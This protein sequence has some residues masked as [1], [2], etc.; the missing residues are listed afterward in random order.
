M[1]TI[2]IHAYIA[3]SGYTSRRKA[4][5]LVKAKKVFVNNTPAT[6]GQRID[7]SSDAV[8]IIEK[9]KTVSLP[10]Q[11][12]KKRYFL[13]N[14]P[15]GVVSTTSDPDN[16]PTIL[17][18][19]PNTVERLYPVGRLDEES[20]GLLI[21]TNDGSL[22]H[23]LTHPSFQYSKSYQVLLEKPLTS[24]AKK[25]LLTGISL[26]EGRVRAQS[27]EMDAHDP[28]VITISI[29]QGWNR[30]VRRMLGVL[31][32]EVKKLTRIAHGPF[33]LEQLGN[34]PYTQLNVNDVRELMRKSSPEIYAAHIKRSKK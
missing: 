5:E 33:T 2:K 11:Q 6:I 14:K 31:G 15:I 29:S 10:H 30:Q 26:K 18:L 7:P 21:L 20:E 4:E 12:P 32:F 8:S 28:R 25:R 22:T 24:Y 13:V 9:K 27:L 23:Q 19:I 34:A 1:N 3:H 16:K 17:S